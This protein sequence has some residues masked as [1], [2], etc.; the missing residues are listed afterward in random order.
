MRRKVT[1]VWEESTQSWTFPDK[2]DF[3]WASIWPSDD[4]KGWI[5]LVHPDPREKNQ[6]AVCGKDDAYFPA[7]EAN[8]DK[9]IWLCKEC[10]K[11]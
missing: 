8:P 11:E 5:L 6:C 2:G 10:H 9:Q 1:L 7:Q 3:T 4:G